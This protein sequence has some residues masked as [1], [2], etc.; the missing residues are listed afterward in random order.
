MVADGGFISLRSADGSESTRVP[1]NSAG[2]AFD[3]AQRGLRPA[4]LVGD[5][6]GAVAA[7]RG[8]GDAVVLQADG[9][10]Q[11]LENTACLDPFRPTPTRGGLVLACRSGQL[12]TVS[13]KA[14]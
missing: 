3:A 11:R 5:R 9:T 8:A 13:D 7:V 10:V 2:Q 1:L 4:L 12:F 6:M 14:P